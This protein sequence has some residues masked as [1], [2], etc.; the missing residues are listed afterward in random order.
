MAVPGLEGG[1][2]AAGRFQLQRQRRH[3]VAAATRPRFDALFFDEIG[4]KRLEFARLHLREGA[5]PPIHIEALR[6]VPP[7][8]FQPR[9]RLWLIERPQLLG[10]ALLPALVVMFLELAAEDVEPGH[11]RQDGDQ[12]GGRPPAALTLNTA[13]LR[14]VG[15]FQRLPFAPLLPLQFCFL[16]VLPHQHCRLLGFE[17]P[18]APGLSPFQGI[19]AIGLALRLL[20]ILDRLAVLGDQRLGL[21]D[22]WL[23]KSEQTGT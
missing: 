2:A 22:A 19:D 9:P 3:A 1:I 6:L 17:H 8:Q 14:S 7:L 4:F 21:V 13:C 23:Q 11:P 15:L 18:A 16:F 20:E 12:T 10:Q 5:K